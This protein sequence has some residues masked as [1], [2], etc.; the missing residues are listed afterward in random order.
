MFTR[1]STTKT[2]LVIAVLILAL[3]AGN[4][5]IAYS[6]SPPIH[7]YSALRTTKGRPAYVPGQL[8]IEFAPTASPILQGQVLNSYDLHLIEQLDG[9]SFALVEFDP[10]RDP[11]PPAQKLLQH[12]AVA[13][14]EPN[15][16]RYAHFEPNDT[17]FSYQWHFPL[18]QVP[19][20]WDLS[21]GAEVTVAIVD[22]GVA[23]ETYGDYQ[24]AP[25]L[26]GTAFA[27]GYDFINDDEH[28]NDDNGHGTHVAG[29]IAQTTNNN[30]G[31]AGIAFDAKIM[32][33]KALDA[34]GNGS[35][36]EVAQGIRWATDHGA[37]IINLSLGSPSGSSV[38]EDAVQYA[39]DN[40]VTVVASSGNDGTNS[41]GYPAAYDVVIAVGAVQY[42]ET[43]APYSDHGPALDVVAPGGNTH[44]DQNGD[45][46]VDGVLQQTFNPYT[47]NPADF[48]YYFFQGTSMAAPHVAGAAALLI[49]KGVATTSNEIR[50]ALEST[51]KDLGAPGRDNTYGYG[52]IQIADALIWNGSPPVTPSPT[53]AGPTPT[54]TPSTVPAVTPTPV[55]DWEARA[56]QLI[57]QER[58]DRDKP[59]LSIDHRLVEAARRH[60]QDMADND[61]FSHYGSDGSS[62]FDRIRD[63][64]YNFAT[65]GEAIAGGYSSPEAAVDAWM[66][67][68]PHRAIL[69][70][71]Y[72][73]VGVGYVYEVNSI[74][75]YYWTA[76]FAVP[77]GDNATATP[78]YTPT[79]TSTLTATPRLTPTNTNTPTTTP[80]ATLSSTPATT[81]TITSTTSPTPT[82]ATPEIPS[83]SCGDLNGNDIV[84][85]GDL[86][87]AAAG[88]HDNTA[89]SAD[90][91]GDDVVDI[92]DIMTIAAQWGTHCTHN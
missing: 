64:G 27:D 88:W 19:E 46:Y 15:Y 5:P 1:L 38:E 34:D 17:H 21:T 71:N 85:I 40:G 80:T 33:I 55:E 87:M 25:D 61:I 66:N 92:R 8:I 78:R 77:S 43:L 32:P 45:G 9:T 75:R 52:L 90:L 12:P 29:T 22:T 28:P 60:S 54:F 65:A 35:A 89:S 48:A 47:Q 42:D 10:G 68:P 37:D 20:A 14:A 70:G 23:Y 24:Q 74:Y 69:L 41:V 59:A 82:P 49:A 3:L 86:Q 79:G 91:N 50:A 56:V 51:A 84:G 2:G 62:P 63:A 4:G 72:T 36:W 31:V 81:P 57:N 39:Y 44:V 67:S 26:A 58:A 7:E 30:Q 18:I 53:P 76:N 11:L 13:S 73:D 6:D 16:Y 83:E